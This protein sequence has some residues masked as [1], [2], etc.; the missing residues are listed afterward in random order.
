MCS[1]H[2][3]KF[4]RLGLLGV[5]YTLIILAASLASAQ[6]REVYTLKSQ[7]GT[8]VEIRPIGGYYL[9]MQTTS[10]AAGSMVLPGGQTWYGR[11][12]VGVLANHRWFRSADLAVFH[13]DGSDSTDGR[14]E[15]KGVREGEASDVLGGFHFVEL[16]WAVPGSLV[17]IA[18]AFQLY[19]DRPA[20]VFVERFPKGFKGYANGNWPVPS[21]AFPQFVSDNWAIPQNLYSWTSGG[22]WTHR[23]AWGD[24]FSNQGSVD[25]LVTSAPDYT[26]LIL[27]SFGNYLIS[28]QQNG[29]TPL[30]DKISRGGIS[31]GI[32]GLVPE[33]PLG[34]EQK[35]FWSPAR[36][37][38]ARSPSG[39]RCC[40]NGRDWRRGEVCDHGADMR[41]PQLKQREAGC[42]S[43]SVESGMESGHLGLRCSL[44]GAGKLAETSS[45]DRLQA[46]E[47]GWFWDRQTNLRHVKVDFAGVQEMTAKSFFTH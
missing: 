22:M 19:K 25:P 23:L 20:L 2:S 32:E 44:A 27:S 6:I 46:A 41:D 40:S 36:E 34:F 26:T 43:G 10:S 18:T 4:V 21:I 42:M 29:P 14:L 45:L 1:L 39:A 17:H 28:T 24:A 15:L 47:S 30:A 16:E 8:A 38:T 3:G 31:C 11:G 35:H 37:F 13:A 9:V 12:I 7:F 33:L 5:A